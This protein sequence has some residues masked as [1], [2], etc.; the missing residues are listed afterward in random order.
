[1]PHE[2]G[3][4]CP[5]WKGKQGS[6]RKESAMAKQRKAWMFDQAK[7]LK[8]ALS[9]TVKDEVETKAKELVET[10]LKPKHIQPPPKAH[11]LNYITEI[12]TKWVG[13]KFYF[14]SIY[15]CPGPNAISPTFEAKFAR[16]ELVAET[17][18][19]LS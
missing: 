13:S 1:M 8:S 12:T 17:K 19:N 15:S 10:V 3:G 16:L 14:V 6:N 18:F 2:E 9:G 4:D 7:R 5:C 11:D